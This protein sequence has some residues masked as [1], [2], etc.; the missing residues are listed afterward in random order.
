MFLLRDMLGKFLSASNEKKKRKR[1]EKEARK[2]VLNRT[3]VVIATIRN[4]I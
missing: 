2:R 3:L 1:E 4:T